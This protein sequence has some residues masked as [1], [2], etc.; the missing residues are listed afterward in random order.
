MDTP[1]GTNRDSSGR[2]KS[3]M[4]EVCSDASTGTGRTEA[5]SVGVGSAEPVG[6]EPVPDAPGREMPSPRD[7]EAVGV[8]DGSD[9]AVSDTGIV[10]RT[11]LTALEI[12]DTTEEMALS[13]AVGMASTSDTAEE[14]RLLTGARISPTSDVRDAIVLLTPGSKPGINSDASVVVDG[15]A[16]DLVVE[17]WVE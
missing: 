12:L 16:L 15:S 1:V 5:D 4:I 6:L 8:A 9:S 10:G 11:G 3:L 17:R 14:M 13:M 7:V 2:S